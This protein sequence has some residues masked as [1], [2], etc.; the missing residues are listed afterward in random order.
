MR[1]ADMILL[2]YFYVTKPLLMLA[3]TGSLSLWLY[4]LFILITIVAMIIAFYQIKKGTIET[5][6][7]DKMIDLFKYVIVSTAL[8]T[9]T[10]VVADL[11]KEREQDVKELEYFDKYVNDVKQADGIEARLRLTKYLSIVAPGG[12]LKRSWQ[13]YYDTVY[14]EYRQY[15]QKKRE[16]DS[17]R[18]IDN[19]TDM[20]RQE[21]L[22]VEA[23]IQQFEKPLMDQAVTDR[24]PTVYIQYCNQAKKDDILA[25]QQNFIAHAWIAPGIELVKGGCDNSIR[26]F[27]EE[28]KALALEANGLTGN[29]CT[30]TRSLLRAPKGQIEVWINR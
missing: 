24:K 8:S 1:P 29:T 10:L 11:F 19:P 12:A 18:Q 20:Q 21:V 27:H 17:L 28:D 2:H 9:V 6:K 23:S 16:A 15:D 14:A 5:E 26:Y 22:K 30:L 3:N 25:M 4:G 13:A 7:L